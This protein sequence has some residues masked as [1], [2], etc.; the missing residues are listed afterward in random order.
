MTKEEIIAYVMNTPEN[1]NPAILSQKI[2]EYAGENSGTNESLEDNGYAVIKF[3]LTNEEVVITE[4]GV[5]TTWHKAAPNYSFDEVYNIMNSR[6]PSLV[7]AYVDDKCI[8]LGNS[9]YYYDEDTGKG[10]I[11]LVFTNYNSTG[12]S[13]TRYSVKFTED[14]C[15]YS[16]TETSNVVH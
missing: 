5:S 15:V 4:E 2:D 11:N 3:E 6:I 1:T 13:G 12:I 8:G 16:F 14:G 9:D 7:V 10:I